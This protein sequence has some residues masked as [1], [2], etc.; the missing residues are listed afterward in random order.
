MT[1]ICDDTYLLDHPYL[2]YYVI[3]HTLL[4]L[5]VKNQD[6]IKTTKEQFSNK[7]RIS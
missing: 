6:G 7:H 5:K 3:K 2:I 1:K 4:N